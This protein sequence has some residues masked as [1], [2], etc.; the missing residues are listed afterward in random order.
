MNAGIEQHTDVCP[1]LCDRETSI[2]SAAIV[3]PSFLELEWRHKNRKDPLTIGKKSW[4][5]FRSEKGGMMILF[6][7][8]LDLGGYTVTA[9]S[10]VELLFAPMAVN[11]T[12]RPLAERFVIS[13]LNVE[14]GSQPYRSP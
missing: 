4:P 6:G 14:K 13:N 8:N 5:R 12:R 9:S 7:L 10:E 11:E 1:A 2:R 3:L